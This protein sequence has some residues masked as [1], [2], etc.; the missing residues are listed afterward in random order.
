MIVICRVL[1]VNRSSY[2]DWLKS[3]PSKRQ[4]EDELI[5]SKI[6]SIFIDSRCTYGSRR[7]RQ[8][9]MN[10]G[11]LISRRRVKKLMK[12][13]GLSCKTKR[14]Y[15]V[16][17]DSKHK[18]PI[19]NNILNRDFKALKP[20]TK[21]VGDITY[22]WTNEGWL[23]LAV[24]IDLYYRKVV[25]WSLD[26]TMTATLVN[27]ALRM[28]IKARKPSNGFIWHT[29]RGSQYASSSHRALLKN[30][31]VIQSMSRKGNCWDNSVSESFFPTLKTELTYHFQFI[32]RE[33]AKM[34]IF[35]YIEV[36]L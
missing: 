1:K 7:L 23:Y 13:M 18:E 4:L 8:S 34:E 31:G 5:S 20:N 27:E 6:K 25:G 33:E 36:F 3:S 14:R 19:A 32:I 22:V 35:E 2:Y 30:Y 9:L 28:A 24:V 15:K 26:K 21:Y 17:T 10:I 11:F 29:D 16:T 12:S